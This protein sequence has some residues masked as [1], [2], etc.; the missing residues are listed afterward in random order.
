[1]FIDTNVLVRARFTVAPS[2]DLARARLR[3]ALGSEERPRI[4][5]QIVREYLAVVTRSQIWSVPLPM[6]DALQDVDW[7]V[8]EFDILEEGPD[9]THLLAELCREVPVAGR[10]VHDANIV[11]TMLA[12]AEQRLLTFDQGDFRRYGNRISLIDP[13]RSD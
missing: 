1:M 13:T 7:F 3:E 12:H 2:H 10:Q 4:S 6:S 5:R 8:S 9:V 11:A